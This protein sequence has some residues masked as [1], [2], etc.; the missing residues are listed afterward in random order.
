MATNTEHYNL[1][2]GQGSD[3][4]NLLTQVFPN[5]ETIDSAMFSN[6][7]NSIGTATE[8]KTG[9]IHAITKEGS[10]KAFLFYAVAD[11]NSGDSFTVN[12]T[13]VSSISPSGSPLV[14]GAFTAGSNVLCVY[15]NGKL[16]VFTNAVSQDEVDLSG[17]MKTSDY[18][19]SSA[20]GV[21][22]NSVNA[23]TATTALN[24]NNLNNLPASS[25]ATAS[26]INPL[27][28]NIQAIQVVDILPDNPVST[29]LYLV[30][31]AS[32]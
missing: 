28:Q 25:Y 17:Y 4:V 10:Q 19:G 21:V 1:I 11:F 31:E 18:V 7:E 2:I 3:Y 12:G 13:P 24:A 16:T 30:K 23:T 27:I 22:Q 9:T 32:E 5:F 29:T 8:I 20:S 15:D 6:Q 14:Q 26:Q